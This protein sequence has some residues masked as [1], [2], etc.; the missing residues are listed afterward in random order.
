MKAVSKEINL[1]DRRVTLCF[2]TIGICIMARTVT[3]FIVLIIIT[4]PVGF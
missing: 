2:P 4:L 3:H 1:R